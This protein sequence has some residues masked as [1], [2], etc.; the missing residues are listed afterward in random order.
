MKKIF[1]KLIVLC[2]SLILTNLLAGEVNENSVISKNDVQEQNEISKSQPVVEEETMRDFF[3][4]VAKEIGFETYGAKKD[5]SKFFF[6]GESIVS[7]KPTD[8]DFG[9]ALV[10]AYEKAILDLQANY[11]VDT[12]GKTSSERMSN[13]Y[14]DK[15]TN[16]KKFE[17][18]VRN[19]GKIE[20]II[21]KALDVVEANLD[22]ALKEMG[23][24]TAKL[25]KK[26]KKSLFKNEFIKSILT[27]SYGSMSGLVPI[28]TKIT[29]DKKG[30]YSVGV[31]AVISEKTK[32]IAKDMALKRKSLISGK[33]KDINTL[34]PQNNEDFLNELGIRLTYDLEGKPTIISYGRWSY[35]EDSNDSYINKMAVQTALDQSKTLADAM[36]VEFMN[37]RLSFKQNSQTGEI[38][39][40][41]VTKEIDS[42][43]G[44]ENL[45]E[46]V[47][48]DIVDKISKEI[49]AK[50]NGSL[51]GI[52][53]LTDWEATDKNGINHVGV[54][55]VWSY[56]TVEAVNNMLKPKNET[57]NNSS[58]TT[59]ITR[60]SKQINNV[61][62]F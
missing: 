32:Q 33:G 37:T 20:G 53:T 25:N 29:M 28:K 21:N 10:I 46:E 18:E 59:T 15:S 52:S 57:I 26:Q 49:K 7:L 60:E 9:K 5:G 24:D 44:S 3:R 38:I 45:S 39:D 35:T 16:A 48:K 34:I 30:N 22:E 40:R 12:F 6:K 36:I 41:T 14:Q 58:K 55:R 50:A 54:V 27:S 17:E 51:R 2:M 42:E 19:E 4:R 11:I 13:L 62:D 61:N 1:I 31:V 56:D 8:P 43:S 23:K 47:I